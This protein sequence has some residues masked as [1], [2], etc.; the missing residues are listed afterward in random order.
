MD[1]EVV[2]FAGSGVYG[3]MRCRDA[4]VMACILLNEWW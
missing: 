4:A 2:V 1:I 3:V